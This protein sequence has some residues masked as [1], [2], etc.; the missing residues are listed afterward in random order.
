MNSYKNLLP[1]AL[2][3]LLL[4][5]GCTK[6]DT[7]AD[8]GAQPTILRVSTAP[9][10]IIGEQVPYDTKASQ[11]LFPEHENVIYSLAILIFDEKEGVLRSFDERRGKHYKYIDLKDENGNGLLSTELPTTGFPVQANEKYT[12]CL[13]ANLSETQVAAIVDGMMEDGVAFLHEFQQVA[14][15]IPYVASNQ[16]DGYW[17]TGHVREVYMFGYYRGEV[18]P[19]KEISITL[20]RI[21]S[22]LEIAFA[23]DKESLDPDKTFYMRM[24]NLESHAHLF[25]IGKSPGKYAKTG[26]SHVPSLEQMQH[27]IYFYSAPNGAP[28]ENEA[29]NLEVWYGPKELADINDIQKDYS[30][31]TCIYLCND[32]PEVP[33]RNYW[34]HRNSVY[35]FNIKL[36][37][38]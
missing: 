37:E 16:S 31:Y 38:K 22:R 18:Q 15:P 3:A 34:L 8:I 27:T 35:R 25:P 1:T 13:I 32:Q 4:L 28:S 21:I 5:G 20:G 10:N 12:V 30:G 11:P 36:T 23:I 17:E 6:A 14:V 19:Y 2:S 26:I 9:M 24:N 7:A 33:N 29:L